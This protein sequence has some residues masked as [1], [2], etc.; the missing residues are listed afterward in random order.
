MPENENQY[1]LDKDYAPLGIVDAEDGSGTTWPEFVGQV[2]K[3]DNQVAAL[4]EVCDSQFQRAVKVGDGLESI[5]VEDDVEGVIQFRLV[6]TKKDWTFFV[7][8]H[9]FGV[10]DVANR[11]FLWK[12]TV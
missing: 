3:M 9:E 7:G 6:G 12:M 1:E 5:T 8:A 10:Y 11:K 4:T 2:N